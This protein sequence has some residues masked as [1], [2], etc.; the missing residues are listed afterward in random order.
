MFVLNLAVIHT[1]VVEKGLYKR[2]VLQNHSCEDG[3]CTKRVA[4]KGLQIDLAKACLSNN[5]F[6]VSCD[7]C[8]A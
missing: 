7:I 3:G 6:L 1:G 5:L 8:L 2:G 4:R